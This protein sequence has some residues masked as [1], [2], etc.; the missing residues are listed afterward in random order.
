M[1]LRTSSLRLL[2]G[3]TNFERIFLELLLVV[4]FED[5]LDLRII[6]APPGLVPLLDENLRRR[7]PTRP[8][9]P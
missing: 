7:D 5:I 3:T 2:V 1:L 6:D 9:A 8:A 4:S